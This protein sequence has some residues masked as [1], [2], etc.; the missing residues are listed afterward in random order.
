MESLKRI[1]ELEQ[2]LKQAVTVLEEWEEVSRK[3]LYPHQ[4]N[5]ATFNREVLKNIKDIL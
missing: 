2:A 1:E 4:H 5:T 3:M